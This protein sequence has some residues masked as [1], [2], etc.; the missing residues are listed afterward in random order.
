MIVIAGAL[1][2]ALTGGLTA[3]RRNG[4]AADIAQY[5]AGFGICFALVGLI[6]T[7]AIEKLLV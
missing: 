1:L 2:G 6:L 4:S 5:A 3:R 7:I